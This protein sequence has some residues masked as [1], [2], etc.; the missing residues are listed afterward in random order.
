MEG[1]VTTDGYRVY[2]GGNEKF[3]ELYGGDVSIIQ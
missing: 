3:L 1:E 2:F